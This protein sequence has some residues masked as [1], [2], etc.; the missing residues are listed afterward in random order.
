M[1]GDSTFFI[2]AGGHD[3]S[4]KLAST[5]VQIFYHVDDNPG[6]GWFS[7]VLNLD[8]GTWKCGGDLGIRR[9]GVSNEQPIV[10]EN[11]LDVFTIQMQHLYICTV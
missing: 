11:Y 10:L 6:D 5:E 8:T 3:G 2:I 1:K 4:S 9:Q 7:Q